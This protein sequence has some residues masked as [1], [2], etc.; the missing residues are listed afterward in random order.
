VLERKPKGLLKPIQE[1][2]HWI[3]QNPKDW[4]LFLSE[5]DQLT[6]FVQSKHVSLKKIEINEDTKSLNLSRMMKFNILDFW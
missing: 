4:P 1:G 5:Q 6:S 2:N 3:G